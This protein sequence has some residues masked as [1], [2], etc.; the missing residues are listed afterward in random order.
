MEN[1]CKDNKVVKFIKE[2]YKRILIVIL[3]SIIYSLGLSWF[4]QPANLYSGGVVGLVQLIINIIE[5][6]T[7]Q[8][9]S[10]GI[11]IFLI[12]IPILCVAFKHVSLRFALYSLLSI[13]IQSIMGMGFVPIIDLTVNTTAI[14]ENMMLLSVLG[15]ALVGFGGAIALRYGAS[16]GGIDIFAQALALKKNVSIGLFSLIFNVCIAVIGGIVLNSWAIVLYTCIRIVT[17]SIVT[18]KIHTTYNHL[19]LEIITDFG[20]EISAMIMQISGRGVTVINAEGAYSH[21][22]KF[23]LETVVSS[24]EMYKIVESAKKLDKHVFVIAS[25]VK[26]IVGN[27]KKRTVA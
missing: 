5:K 3:S 7:N 9:A 17:T 26:N 15:G 21:K 6:Y 14:A 1:Q 27:F 24:F 8:T 22:R 20:E 4:L 25:P 13:V 16:T 18:D 19:K 10:I 2:E 23:V 11:F 12:N